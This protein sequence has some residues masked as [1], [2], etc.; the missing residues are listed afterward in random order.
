MRYKQKLVEC[1]YLSTSGNKCTRKGNKCTRKLVGSVCIYHKHV[2]KCPY[3]NEWV[4]ERIIDCGLP[5]E[6]IGLSEDGDE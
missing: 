2:E 4:E 6:Q 1:P 3:Y 5:E